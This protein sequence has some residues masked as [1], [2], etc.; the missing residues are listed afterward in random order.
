MP[1]FIVSEDITE[2]DVD[3][4]VNAANTELRMGGGVCGAIFRAAGVEEMEEACHPLSPVKTG[5]A[6]IT[7]GFD[8][9]ARYV[10]HTPGPV[11]NPEQKEICEEQLRAS[12]RNSMEL[13]A[14][15]HCESLAFPL[16][17][18]GAYGYPKEEALQVAISVIREFLRTHEMEIYLTLLTEVGISLPSGLKETVESFTE[19]W[20]DAPYMDGCL[21]AGE[22]VACGAPPDMDDYQVG[23]LPQA[24]FDET[25]KLN[26]FRDQLDEPFNKALLR[27]IDNKGKTDVEVYK[28]AN[29]SRKLFSKIRTG[30]GYMPG[31]RTILALAVGLELDVD[32]TEALL[33]HAGFTLSKSILSDVI[34]EYFIRNKKYDIYDINDALFYYH[35]PLLGSA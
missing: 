32:E 22:G 31:K 27:L 16:I 30:R 3:A 7:P 29:I 2:M 26:D 11:Y 1:F 19:E 6:V 21:E 13:A 33:E 20:A 24:C 15:Y 9:P 28:K 25:E 35:Q 34:V 17:S 14:T 18:S 5:E 10:I 23:S 4:V 12:Y 8:L